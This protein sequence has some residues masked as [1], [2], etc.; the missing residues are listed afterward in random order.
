MH[1]ARPIPPA[2]IMTI[3]IM[4]PNSLHAGNRCRFLDQTNRARVRTFEGAGRAWGVGSGGSQNCNQ[5]LT[6]RAIQA[7]QL[8]KMPDSIDLHLFYSKFI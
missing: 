8:K 3:A 4:A 6:G 1:V 7:A 2:L 5:K